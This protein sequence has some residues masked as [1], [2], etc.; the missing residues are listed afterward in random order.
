M[1]RILTLGNALVDIMV[2]LTNDDLLTVLG[3]PRGS[4]QHTDGE[5]M[6]R[7][8]SLTQGLERVVASGGSAANTAN[9]LANL[10][11][12]V[13]YVGCVGADG[14]GNF[15]RD[16]MIANRIKPELFT[17]KA[18]TGIA[19]V[20][21]SPDGERTFAV[22][23]GAALELKPDD[24]QPSLFR[25]YD[26]LHIEGYL[27]QNHNLLQRALVLA[28][29]H[30]LRVSLDLASYNVVE[31]NLDFLKRMV[32]NYVDIVFA[33]EDEAKA[34]TGLEPEGAVNGL[35][36]L[37][38]IAVVKMGVEGSLIKGAAGTFRVGIVPARAIDTTGAGDM[39]AAG[40]LYGLTRGLSLEACGQLGAL[41]SGRVVEVMGPKMVKR[42]WE[43]IC[44][45]V[46]C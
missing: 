7:I 35:A 32:E 15:F 16:D 5:T 30:G 25:A 2:S 14:L 17:A 4:M 9:G 22:N 44:M 39:Y 1:N 11:A 46:K 31:A 29:D 12:D 27:V 23:L 37:A 18:P 34:F 6:E 21:V 3:L 36:R 33:N 13:T 26:F 41:V 40:F 24:L 28:K 38:S 8:V 10:G 45:A 20:F 19:T 43:E 42:T